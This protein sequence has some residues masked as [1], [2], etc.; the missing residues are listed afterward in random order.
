MQETFTPA[1]IRALRRAEQEARDLGCEGTGTEH[2]LM[3]LVRT[4]AIEAELRG[5]GVDPETVYAACLALFTQPRPPKRTGP[6]P[7]SPKVLH[8]FEMAGAG[9]GPAEL[10][11]ALMK[12]PEGGAFKA[13]QAIPQKKEGPAGGKPAGPERER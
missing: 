3:G 6:A 1:A 7:F 13:M 9:A 11:A 5:R 8:V 2:V 10:F 4:G 12:E